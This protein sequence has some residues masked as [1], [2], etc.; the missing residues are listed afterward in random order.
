[1][2]SERRGGR[3]IVGHRVH[4][5]LSPGQLGGVTAYATTHGLSRAEAVRRLIETGL[6]TT[7]PRTIRTKDA[8]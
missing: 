8:H 6:R 2:E 7:S 5:H 1:M 3:P 4:V